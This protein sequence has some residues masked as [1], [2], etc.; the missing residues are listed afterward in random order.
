[1]IALK[2]EVDSISG[3]AVN[4]QLEDLVA[5]MAIISEVPGLGNAI[6][7][8]QNGSFRLLVFQP[9]EPI[10]KWLTPV[11]FK[12]LHHTRARLNPHRSIVP[13]RAQSVKAMWIKGGG[14]MVTPSRVIFEGNWP[15]FFSWMSLRQGFRPSSRMLLKTVD[16]LYTIGSLPN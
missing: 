2:T 3:A 14:A 16:E 4:P 6:Q 8:S 11:D 5:E 1:V 9:Q 13:Y 15:C 7:P 12:F 10:G